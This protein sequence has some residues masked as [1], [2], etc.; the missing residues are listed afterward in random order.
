MRRPRLPLRILGLLFLAG[1]CGSPGAPSGD[2]GLTARQE[3][4][5]RNALHDALRGDEPRSAAGRDGLIRIGPAAVPI[6][7]EALAADETLTAEKPARALRQERI[8]RGELAVILG[9]IR[10]ARAIPPLLAHYDGP[11]FARALEKITGQSLGDSL[12]AWREW[13]VS[14]APASRGEV[15]AAVREYRRQ[16]TAQRLQ[17]LQDLIHGIRMRT[18]A[19][20]LEKNPDS[21]LWATQLQVQMQ[22]T[23]D[24]DRCRAARTLLI[25]AFRDPEPMIRRHACLLALQLGPLAVQPLRTLLQEVDP[26]TR[27]QVTGVLAEIGDDHA[28]PELMKGLSDPS[29]AIR[30][31]SALALGQIGNPTASPAL[32]EQLSKEPDPLVRPGLLAA[33]VMLGEVARFEDLVA[34]LNEGSGVQKASVD[35][36]AVVCRRAFS[37]GIQRVQRLRLPKAGMDW[38]KCWQQ[39]W[40]HQQLGVDPERWRRWWT[41]DDP[42]PRALFLPPSRTSR[43]QIPEGGEQTP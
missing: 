14:Q 37:L 2:A 17:I 30:Q 26:E 41:A 29:S 16:G 6:L 15:E 35:H 11:P 28:L 19:V 23:E 32:R 22:S 3:L 24:L 33:L 38:E 20:V 7:L 21:P 5:I 13:Y 40:Q 39:Y 18:G 36:L 4:E 8:R 27:L 42:C 9:E 1:G 12:G 31:R 34:L 43:E 25:P 10:D